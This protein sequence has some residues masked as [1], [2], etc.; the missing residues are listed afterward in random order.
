MN[1]NYPAEKTYTNNVWCILNKIKHEL[2]YKAKN[3][4]IIDYLFDLN[5]TR[6]NPGYM[7]ELEILEKLKKDKIISEVH[8]LDTVEINE[9]G[10]QNQKA[11]YLYHFKVLGAFDAY[12]DLYYRSLLVNQ[13]YCWFENN[14]FFLTLKDASVKVISFDTERG[15]RGL[16][17]M[18][19]VLVDHWKKNGNKPISGDSM[20]KY[21]DNLGVS[22]ERHQIKDILSNI[23]NK[24]IKPA[25]LDDKI[26]ISFSKKLHGWTVDIK[27]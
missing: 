17:T 1:M 16:L 25:K 9:S 10:K 13:S 18:F 8:P 14:A 19:Q 3:D 12:Y 24:K 15:K 20:I 5:I 11:Y 4:H 26:F 23:R 6:I 21:M 27:R 7:E 2:L 22:I